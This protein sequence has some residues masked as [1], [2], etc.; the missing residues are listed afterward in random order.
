[1]RTHLSLLFTFALA[2]QVTAE[3]ATPE[4]YKNSSNSAAVA[5]GSD[6]WQLFND[7][8]L[9]DLLLQVEVNSQSIKGAEAS[10]R[11]A[12]AAVKNA[13]ADFLPSVDGTFSQNRQKFSGGGDFVFPQLT[14]DTVSLSFSAAYEVDLWGRVRKNVAAAKNDLLASQAAKD[15]LSLSLRGEVASAYFQLRAADGELATLR[16]TVKQRAE[17]LQLTQAKLDAGTGNDLDVERAKT[18]LASSEADVIGTQD[19]RNQLENALALLVGQPASSFKV[20]AASSANQPPKIPSG[21]PSELLKRRPDIIQA[22][23]QLTAA[24]ARV[25]VAK[26]AYFPNLQLTG[27][28]GW[29]GNEVERLTKKGTDTWN[30]G[31]QFSIPLFDGG[32]RKAALEQNKAGVDAAESTYQQ[33]VL[34]ALQEVENGLGSVENIAKQRA[35]L[36]KALASAR[37]AAKLSRSRYDSGLVSYFEVID[38]ERSVLLWERTSTQLRGQHFRAVAMLIKALGGGWSK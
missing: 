14:Q 3:V 8:T 25:G 11:Q 22:E 26:A 28:S 1:M 33:A 32:R 9:S 17:A 19:Q 31:L 23:Q 27:G 7:Q 24:K 37:N 35:A 34:T 30:L 5:S 6:W 20:A 16:D 29:S 4:A 18:E 10:I 15:G 21:L 36:D 2:S 13:Q 12:Q 38:S